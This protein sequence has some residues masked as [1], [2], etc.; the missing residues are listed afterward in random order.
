[1]DSDAPGPGLRDGVLV[2]VDHPNPGRAMHSCPDCQEE[3]ISPGEH[4]YVVR[5]SPT[6]TRPWIY[7][8]KHSTAEISAA[9]S[10]R[11]PFFMWLNHQL[12]TSQTPPEQ[13]Q[14]TKIELEF[15]TGNALGTY[16]E[17]SIRS[18]TVRVSTLD[19]TWSPG[20]FDVVSIFGISSP[21]RLSRSMCRFPSS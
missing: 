2:P 19:Y 17:D 21:L 8:L 1:M 20:R 18:V 10:R 15:E 11:C 7:T 16:V 13:L 5:S 3:K 6:S 9:A 4:L 14:R 12:V